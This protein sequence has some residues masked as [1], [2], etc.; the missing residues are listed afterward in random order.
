MFSHLTV[1]EA[2]DEQQASSDR[3]NQDNS[4]K[5][6]DGGDGDEEEENDED[7]DD[8]DE[9][10]DESEGEDEEDSDDEDEE[11]KIGRADICLPKLETLDIH[12]HEYTASPGNLEYWESK[13]V[14]GQITQINEVT[15]RCSPN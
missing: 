6:E 8:E 12:L 10:D 7:D 4:A 5:V 9:D 14:N 11:Y 2:V 1:A 15:K 3:I 13:L